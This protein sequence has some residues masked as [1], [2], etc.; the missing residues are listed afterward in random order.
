MDESKSTGERLLTGYFDRFTLEHLHRYGIASELSHGKDVLDIASGE[1]Y[2]SDLLATKS[3]TVC[4]VDIDPQVVN[5]SRGK[6]CR[7]N[8]RFL[9]GSADAIPLTAESV[10]V[11]VSFETLEHHDR[12]EEMYLE[13]KR[14][15]RPDGILVISTPNKK[16]FSDLTDHRNAYHVRELYEHEFSE[17][18][19]RHFRHSMMLDQKIVFGSLIF[20]QDHAE[21]LTILRGNHKVITQSKLG[22]EEPTYHFCIASDLPLKR[23]GSTFFDGDQVLRDT[24][25]RINE[26]TQTNE[27][28]A[29]S[30]ASLRREIN[31][32]KKSPTF[33]VGSSLLTPF[34]IIRNILRN[35]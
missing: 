26:L 17:L 23:L 22:I 31:D 4:G 28:F 7:D 15:L 18:N 24:D 8:L 29:S 12:H 32:L 25:E 20:G 9:V 21:G 3:K 19:R 34:R 13:I 35:I 1:G 33:L 11:V 2:G 27:Q 14:V 10:D 16:Y 6:Y 30:N 5:H